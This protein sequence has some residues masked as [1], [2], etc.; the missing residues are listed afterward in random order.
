MTALVL[1]T[2]VVFLFLS[3]LT[4]FLT[5]VIFDAL[6]HASLTALANL[7]ALLQTQYR[8]VFSTRPR[9]FHRFMELPVEIRLLIYNELMVHNVDLYRIRCHS[10]RRREEHSFHKCL[11]RRAELA[12]AQILRTSKQIYSE[13]LPILCSENTVHIECLECENLEFT[14]LWLTISQLCKF[15]TELIESYPG[16]VN[17]VKN[18][19]I[20]SVTPDPCQFES[21]TEFPHYWPLLE[22]QLLSCYENT[23]RI[24]LR[25]RTSLQRRPESQYGFT[26][27]LVR[28][29]CKPTTER[30]YDYKSVIAE[31]T[32]NN[33]RQQSLVTLEETCDA[34]LLSHSQGLLKN[35]A[36]AVQSICW[37]PKSADRKDILLY[38]GCDKYRASDTAIEQL[39][40]GGA[41]QINEDVRRLLS[42]KTLL[43]LAG[44]YDT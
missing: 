3:F 5:L 8:I 20:V 37:N 21:I 11:E 26:V 39:V 30:V 35:T 42:P 19:A 43:N 7:K 23:K 40:A 31:W 38:L 1:L 28:R 22:S 33:L 32:A 29:G 14:P 4:A 12:C 36:F 13:T 17:N 24:S 10:C 2:T 16:R 9:T 27:D 34:I 18:I 15:R 6:T 44:V 25:F 41:G